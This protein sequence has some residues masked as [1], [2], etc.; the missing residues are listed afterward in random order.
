M[1]ELPLKLASV[2]SAYVQKHLR[3]GSASTK[4]QYLVTLHNLAKFLGREPMLS[5]LS[6]GLVSDMMA[7][8]LSRGRSAR[9]ANKVRSNLHCLWSFAA[10]QG[11]VSKWPDT[12]KLVEPERIPVAW[13]REE[14]RVLFRCLDSQP[15]EIAGIPAPLWWH[16]IHAVIWDTGER[17]GAVM[18]LRRDRVSLAGSRVTFIAETRK[19]KRRDR[20]HQLHP[21][22]VGL[23][24]KIWKP[25]R[26]LVF[27]WPFNAYYLWVKYRKLVA[28]AGPPSD[29][30]HRFHCLRKSA[31]SYFEAAG[32]DATALL[33][34]ADRKVTVTHYLD[35]SIVS[36]QQPHPSS[37]LFRPE[38]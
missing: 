12:R 31:A 22:T 30:M 1:L 29:R 36:R 20:Q 7:W 34:H 26:D 14:M 19:G 5:D 37:V 38:Q 24:R 6:D 21:D 16:G 27:P 10:R 35:P 25:E 3:F 2:M 18:Q 8:F 15:G 9:G 4:K 33:D 11:W 13:S 32:G 23:L 28:R 17:I